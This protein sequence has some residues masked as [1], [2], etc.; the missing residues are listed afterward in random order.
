TGPSHSRLRSQTP[1]CRTVP[2]PLPW[3]ACNVFA[4]VGPFKFHSI[5]LCCRL[6]SL[7]RRTT[8]RFRNALHLLEARGSVA[9]VRGIFQRFLALLGESEIGCGYL[10]PLPRRTTFRF[11][12]AL[13]L[14]E[15]RG[16]VAYVRGIF[17]RFLALL[18]ESEIGCGYLI[19]SWLA[20]LGAS[21]LRTDGAAGTLYHVGLW[22]LFQLLARGLVDVFFPRG[23][24]HA[25]L[26]HFL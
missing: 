13:H 12:N 19:T 14:L 5:S 7:P 23:F 9:Y 16:S 11:R 10:D 2:L 25:R 21:L 18:G 17:Q 24:G 20:P 8:F 3:Q 22:Q 15:A 6:D 1:R 26:I 4:L